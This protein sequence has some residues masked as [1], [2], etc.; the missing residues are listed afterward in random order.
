MLFALQAPGPPREGPAVFSTNVQGA[1]IMTSFSQRRQGR[2]F[3]FDYRA[4]IRLPGFAD[5]L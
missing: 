3:N 2:T 4:G 1:H 5:G